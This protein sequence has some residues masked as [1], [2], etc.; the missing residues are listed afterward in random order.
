LTLCTGA[1]DATCFLRLGRVFS[2]VITGNLALL[3]IAVGEKNAGW[4]PTAGWRS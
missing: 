3:G 1:L 4:P 2:S